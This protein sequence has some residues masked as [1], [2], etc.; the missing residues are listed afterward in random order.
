[1]VLVY[2]DTVIFEARLGSHEP[3]DL[4]PGLA[5]H[6]VLAVH[7]PRGVLDCDLTREEAEALSDALHSLSQAIPRSSPVSGDSKPIRREGRVSPAATS[8]AS[9][10]YPLDVT[11]R[12]DTNPAPKSMSH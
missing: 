7:F 1:M 4:A 3:E 8:A 5:D 2:T 12:T 10:S 9:P 11:R 6:V